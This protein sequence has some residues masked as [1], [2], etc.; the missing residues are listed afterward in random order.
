MI[1]QIQGTCSDCG[2]SGEDNRHER[3]VSGGR[4]LEDNETERKLWRF[5]PGLLNKVFVL[6]LGD[7]IKEKDRCKKCKGKRVTEE[8]M[9]LEVRPVN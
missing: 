2:G 8:D 6:L 3:V 9:K 4:N 5:L 1:Q 7:F